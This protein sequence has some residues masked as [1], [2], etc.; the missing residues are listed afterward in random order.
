MDANHLFVPCDFGSNRKYLYFKDERMAFVKCG[1]GKTGNDEFI[2]Y[3][4]CVEKNCLARRRLLNG[5]FERFLSSACAHATHPYPYRIEVTTLAINLLK[6]LFGPPLL[7]MIR[8]MAAWDA[9]SHT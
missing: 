2:Q 1:T 7:G 8:A 3:Y 6:L 4:S 5:I 9:F